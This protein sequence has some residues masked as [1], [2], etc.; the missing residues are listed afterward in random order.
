M[1]LSVV[2]TGP[3]CLFNRG[4]IIAWQSAAVLMCVFVRLEDAYGTVAVQKAG[5][6]PQICVEVERRCS[7]KCLFT[8]THKPN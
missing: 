8:Y 5:E 6:M 3:I 2:I 1:C 7:S 4:N